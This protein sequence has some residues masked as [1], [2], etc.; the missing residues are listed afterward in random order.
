VLIAFSGSKEVDGVEYTEAELNGFAEGDT[1]DKFDT[2]EYRLLIVANKYLTG[3][4]QPKLCAMYVDKKLNG[5]LCMQAL[6]RLNRAAPKWGK[7]TEDLFILDFVNP[8]EE[9]KAS[10]D[11]FYTATSLSGAT[12]I[13]VLHELKDALDDT[14]VYE[15]FEVEE[16][17]A[18]YFNNEDAQLLSAIIDVAAD[19][20]NHELELSNEEKADIKIK[21]QD[22]DADL[23][24]ELLESVDLSSYGLQRVKLNHAITLDDEESELEP[25]NPNPRGAHGTEKETDPLDEIIKN[26]NEKWLQGW[27]STPEEQRV[28]FVNILDSVKKH[29][30]FESKY[31]NNTD[32]INRELAFEKS[33]REVM[34]A[35]RKDE[36]ERFIDLVMRHSNDIATTL[37]YAAEDYFPVAP[38]FEQ[39]GEWV[40]LIHDWCGGYQGGLE[41]AP[42][43]TLP[44]P[45]AAALAMIAEP[46]EK[47]PTSLEAYSNEHLQEQATK[48]RFA[49]RILHAYFLAQRGERPVR[50]QPVVAPIKIGRN[51]PCP[52][53]SGKKYKQCCLH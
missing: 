52:C 29:P 48:A 4:D 27:S 51:E 9:I 26:F 25:Q 43:P 40:P 21:V 16:F 3:F 20:F 10:F 22:P 31:Q 17:V 41:L 12:D 32:P 13:N 33:M 39:H 6:S 8:V 18:R 24:D 37:T 34:L 44:A 36:L 5:V 15:W 28:K 2:N 14:G 53:G 50:S 47:M 23:L 42:W 1:R 19:R 7:K 46:L 11:P 38:E 49:A 45:E 35:R 30:D